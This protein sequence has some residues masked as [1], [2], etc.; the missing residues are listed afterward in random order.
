MG[1]GQLLCEGVSVFGDVVISE[2]FMLPAAMAVSLCIPCRG[3]PFK[4]CGSQNKKDVL[5]GRGLVQIR[6]WWGLEGKKG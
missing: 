2:L 6:C 1:S 5:V 4:P 3:A